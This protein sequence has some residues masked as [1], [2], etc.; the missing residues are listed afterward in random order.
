MLK[1]LSSQNFTC[2]KSKGNPLIIFQVKDIQPLKNNLSDKK[3][4]LILMECMFLHL[5]ALRVLNHKARWF[6]TI[7]T[8]IE[9]WEH[10]KGARKIVTHRALDSDHDGKI[11]SMIHNFTFRHDRKIG[12][13]RERV[14]VQNKN[15]LNWKNNYAL[16]PPFLWK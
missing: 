6:F 7:S 11:S 5:Q 2:Q 1:E 15:K 14:Q 16:F 13:F 10:G 8:E 9:A 3:F 4:S 12:W